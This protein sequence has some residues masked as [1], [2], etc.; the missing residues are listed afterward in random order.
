MA[1]LC[2]LCC[3]NEA[4]ASENFLD[5]QMTRTLLYFLPEGGR[6]TGAPL[7]LK[8]GGRCSPGMSEWQARNIMDPGGL[9]RLPRNPDL[10]TCS[11]LDREKENL[12]LSLRV[13]ATVAKHN[14]TTTEFQ[15]LHS[16]LKKYF[17][18]TRH[19]STPP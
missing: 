3:T 9:N 7:D 4:T 11:S 17:C 12:P 13:S 1:E 18:R 2:D 19:R 5:I 6:K 10:S 14:Q 16:T 15:G 8:A